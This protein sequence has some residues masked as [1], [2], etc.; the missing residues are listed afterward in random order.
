MKRN[1]KTFSWISALLGVFR[2]QTHFTLPR[3][4]REQRGFKGVV[5]LIVLS[6]NAPDPF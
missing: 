2:P 3:F 4:Y 5:R 1:E 6:R